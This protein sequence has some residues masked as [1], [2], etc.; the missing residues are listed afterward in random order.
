MS[1]LDQSLMSSP[2]PNLFRRR[3]RLEKSDLDELTQRSVTFDVL[4]LESPGERKLEDTIT[5]KLYFLVEYEHPKV[6]L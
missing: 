5:S 1:P 6:N 4:P 2:S 3:S